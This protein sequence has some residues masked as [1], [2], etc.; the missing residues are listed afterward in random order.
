[1]ALSELTQVL[2]IYASNAS[3]SASSSSA[4]TTTG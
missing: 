2:E 3:S 1:V 4:T